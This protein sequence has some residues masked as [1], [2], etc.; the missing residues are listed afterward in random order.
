MKENLKS[1]FTVADPEGGG[2]GV[3]PPKITLKCDKAQATLRNR[4]KSLEL[5]IAQKWQTTFQKHQSMNN[6]KI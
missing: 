5:Y 2:G 6:L 3:H 4:S 1:R